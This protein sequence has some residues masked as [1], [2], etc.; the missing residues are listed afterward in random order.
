[1]M[2]NTLTLSIYLQASSLH[3]K[4]YKMCGPYVVTLFKSCVD[5]CLSG[6]WQCFYFRIY[7]EMT[8]V[9]MKLDC[10]LEM[11]ILT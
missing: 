1:M 6:L 3:K 9:R 10:M 5:M 4:P 8:F 11:Y 2:T 7:T